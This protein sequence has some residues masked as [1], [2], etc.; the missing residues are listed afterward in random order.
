MT[1]LQSLSPLQRRALLAAL[2]SPSHSFTR[3][4]AGYVAAGAYPKANRSQALQVE[5]FTKRLMLM[6]EREYLV[7]SDQ[8]GFPTRFALTSKGLQLAQAIAEAAK[9]PRAGAA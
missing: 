8:P 4:R 1:T 7:E 2:A 5:T 9:G 6:L 3:Q